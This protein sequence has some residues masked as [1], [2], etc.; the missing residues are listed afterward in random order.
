MLNVGHTIVQEHIKHLSNGFR[1]NDYIHDISIATESLLGISSSLFLGSNIKNKW[2]ISSNI[3]RKAIHIFSGPL[4]LESWNFYSNTNIGHYSSTI[5]PLFILLGLYLNKN[6][7]IGGLIS[8]DSKELKITSNVG[9]SNGPC[10]Y[11]CVLLILNLIGWK[12]IHS[13]LAIT[14]MA[15]GDGFSDIVGRR[16]GKRKWYF[17][18]NKS[19]VGTCAFFLFSILGS[20]IHL[21]SYNYEIDLRILSPIILHSGILSFVEIVPFGDDNINVPLSSYML[22]HILFADI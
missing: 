22:S 2:N 21:H 7:K 10:I 8:R 19:L 11:I 13:I 17:N 3:T 12:D 18:K 1:T 14:N 9:I 15:Y 5:V 6:K 4:Y 20:M 16:Y